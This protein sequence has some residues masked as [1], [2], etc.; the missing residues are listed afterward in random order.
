MI[1]I[2]GYNGFVGKTVLN[3]LSDQYL[4][5]CGGRQIH[6]EKIT[7][8]I[9]Y[10]KVDVDDTNS[11]KKFCQGC[12]VIVNCIGPS[13]FLA[14]KILGVV[15]KVGAAYIDAFG[16]N[17]FNRRE[18]YAIPV[19]VGAG[20]FP[21]LS[22][23]LP[24]WTKQNSDLEPVKIE[25]FAGGKEKITQTACIDFLSSIINRFGK[26]GVYYTAQGLENE[27]SMIILP[28]VFPRNAIG[29]SY[30]TE[31]LIQAACENNIKELHWY[32]VQNY[33]KYGEVMAEAMIQLMK[34]SS[35]EN[36]KCISNGVIQKIS[37]NTSIDD[38]KYIIVIEV[39]NDEKFLLQRYI[40]EA[41][42]SYVING[43]ILAYCAKKLYEE[44]QEKGIFW[45]FQILD[46]SEIVEK[47]VQNN[48][49]KVRQFQS[50]SVLEENK[51][52]DD[53]I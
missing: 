11:L 31:E 1:G 24:A 26:S 19:V 20:S 29:V 14:E 43:A 42:D 10:V 6:E 23:M 8:G 53:E 51:W 15:E 25:I 18:S 40:W 37:A 22:G 4:I 17:L 39:Q 32:N 52:E 38:L 46:A 7:K 35:Y 50:G 3:Y 34:D 45:P 9:E 47:L 33:P 49:L 36:M 27:N 5:R 2:L 44:R 41:D 16:V 28:E 48:I 13:Y 30:L 12:D 21:G